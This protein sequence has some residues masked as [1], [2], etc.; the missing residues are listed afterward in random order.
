VPDDDDPTCGSNTYGDAEYFLARGRTREIAEHKAL[1]GAWRAAEKAVAEAKTYAC[2][3][4]CPDKKNVSDTL[5]NKP[6]RPKIVVSAPDEDA[7]VCVAKKA[8]EVS[9]DCVEQ[10]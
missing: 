2:P 9:F 1:N 3:Y 6:R 4:Q 5:W 10:D 8:W 7:W